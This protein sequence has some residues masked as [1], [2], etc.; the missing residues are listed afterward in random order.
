MVSKMSMQEDEDKYEQGRIREL[1]EQRMAVQ[2]KT[3][4][5]WM[6]SVFSKNGVRTFQ[7]LHRHPRSISHIYRMH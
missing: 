3:Y 4:T 6:N 1:Q 5:K 7:G 2:K